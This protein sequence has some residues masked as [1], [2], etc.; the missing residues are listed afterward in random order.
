M[1]VPAQAY[2]EFEVHLDFM[3][4]NKLFVNFAAH[5]LQ[6]AGCSRSRLF[7]LIVW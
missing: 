5:F 2:G 6:M 1:P 3:N 4:I 7:S